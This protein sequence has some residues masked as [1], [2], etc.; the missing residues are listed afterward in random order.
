MSNI[1]TFTGNL[2]NDAEVQILP[3]GTP[4]LKFKIANNVGYGTKRNTTWFNVSLFGKLAESTKFTDLMLKGTNVFL[5][6]EFSAR[7]FTGKDGSQKYSLDITA[8]T[9]ELIGNHSTT[10][11]SVAPSPKSDPYQ[12]DMDF[13]IPF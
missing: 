2:G 10:S 12:S 4:V 3:S 5:S 6:G 9:V 8:N 11:S 7:T 1:M 13:D